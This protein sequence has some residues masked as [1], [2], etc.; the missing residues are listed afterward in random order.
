MKRSIVPSG[1]G[2]AGTPRPGHRHRRRF[3]ASTKLSS[4]GRTGDGRHSGR[5]AASGCL[6]DCCQNVGPPEEQHPGDAVPPVRLLLRFL[7]RCCALH[8]RGPVRGADPYAG[9]RAPRGSAWTEADLRINARQPSR[10]VTTLCL[11]DPPA[12][13]E[14]RAGRPQ[15][16]QVAAVLA[17]VRACDALSSNSAMVDRPPSPPRGCSRSA[18]S[19]HARHSRGGGPFCISSH[20]ASHP[21]STQPLPPVTR[22]DCTEL[23]RPLRLPRMGRRNASARGHPPLAYACHDGF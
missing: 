21:S 6:Q 22:K 9:N 11:A 16:V 20:P 3:Q 10:P 18:P 14:L 17:P 23:R 8:R 15:R 12:Y 13:P 5:T 2:R 1:R 4:P 7:D 19:P